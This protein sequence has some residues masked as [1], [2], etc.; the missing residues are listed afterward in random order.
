MNPHDAARILFRWS[1]TET[2]VDRD[3]AK[4]AFV[5]IAH[6]Q[7]GYAPTKWIKYINPGYDINYEAVKLQTGATIP[8][9]IA[10]K[11]TTIYIESLRRLNFR[12]K[13]WYV[14]MR[15]NL[16]TE[17]IPV[18]VGNESRCSCRFCGTDPVG[19][20]TSCRN[21]GAPLPQC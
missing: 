3:Q 9:T 21:C 6:R 7:A 14:Q 5:R 12:G 13:P 18:F 16:D 17:N 20:E 4:N 1:D 11:E 15:V 19:D 2:P 10:G 8:V